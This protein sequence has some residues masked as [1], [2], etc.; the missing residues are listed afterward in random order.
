MKE[1][2][3]GSPTGGTDA[4]FLALSD[5]RR[6][7]VLDAL[8]ERDSSIP[9]S[10]LARSVAKREAASAESADSA[11]PDEDAARVH[12]SLYHSHIP[13]LADAGVVE[14]SPEGGTVGLSNDAALLVESLG[15]PVEK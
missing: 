1:G 3:F 14:Y 2:S 12:L 13:K 10:E 5:P 11:A 7:H 6:R 4:V 9:L 8:R 15:F